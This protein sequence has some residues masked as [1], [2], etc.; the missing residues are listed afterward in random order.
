MTTISVCQEIISLCRDSRVP[1]FIWGAHGI[2]KSSAVRQFT[3]QQRIGFIDLRCAQLESVDVRG[4]PE[5]RNG[6]THFLPPSEFPADGEGL[7]FLDELNRAPD[8]VIA[9]LFQLVLDRRVGEYELPQG[10]TIVAA[11][12]FSH[13]VG[14]NVNELDIAFLDR[15]CHVTLSN[16]QSLLK[17][18]SSWMSETYGE[19]A[20][21][22]VSFCGASSKHLNKRVKDSLPFDVSPTPRSWEAICRG[23]EVIAGKRYSDAAKFNFIAGLV[24]VDLAT[25]FLNHQVTVSA[26]EVLKDGVSAMRSRLSGLNRAALSQLT[27]SLSEARHSSQNKPEVVE[28]VLDYL[29]FLCETQPDLA[30]AC[31]LL[32]LESTDSHA[33]LKTYLP[34]LLSNRRL[35]DRTVQVS[36]GN[37][38]LRQLIQRDSLWRLLAELMVS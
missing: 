25:A 9:A 18:W 5:K 28:V 16:G 2:G 13:D 30:V 32:N 8:D 7:L 10:W 17:P 35:A 15:F 6:R 14:Y 4:L 11:G 26:D 27:S 3:E 33:D 29:V 20:A 24:G 31:A 38:F 12:N 22:I 21:G 36:S 1:L 34:L 23:M 19:A 37:E